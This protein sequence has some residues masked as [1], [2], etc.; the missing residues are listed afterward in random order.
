LFVSVKRRR[1]AALL[2]VLG[3]SGALLGLENLAARK[4]LFDSFGQLEREEGERSLQQVLKALEADLNQLAISNHDYGAWDDA[5][6]FANS[7]DP[8]FLESNFAT[9]TI[10]NLNVDVVWIIDTH[11]RDIVSFQRVPEI[12]SGLPPKA[13]DEVLG[14]LRSQLPGLWKHADTPPLSRLLQT[15]NGLLAFAAHPILP[16]GGRGEPRALL[17]FARFVDDA[18]LKRAHDT[19]QLPVALYTSSQARAVLPAQ[20]QALWGGAPSDAGRV[21]LTPDEKLLNG[22]A[23]I[24]DVNGAPA[25]IVG[26]HIGRK[27]F[28]FGHQTLRYLM[29]LFATVVALFATLL[30]ALL[31]YLEKILHAHQAAE[32][33]YKAVITEAQETMLLVDGDSRCILEANP[34]ATATLGFENA[35][36]VGMAIDD[37]FYAS[38][39]DVLRPVQPE[40]HASARADRILIVRRK[41][42]E[43][44]DVEVTASPLMIDGRESISF[45]LR[46]VSA[47][48]KAERQLVHNQD[49]LSHLAHHDALTGLLNR[50]GL[51]RRLPGL[52]QAAELGSWQVAFLYLDIDHFK[53]IN[54][55]RGHTVGDR[56]LQMA[57]ERLRTCLS[58]DDLIVRMGGDEF[59]VVAS[60]LRDAAGAATIATRIRE[61]LAEPFEVD[62]QE[63][64]VTSSVGV[65][66]YPDD[67]ADYE[68]L[69]KNA[70][71]ALYEAKDTGRDTFTLFSR[72]L[73]SR[74]SERL[75]IEH[76]LRDAIRGGQFFLEYQPLIDLQTNRIASLEALVRW[77]HP[78]RGLVPPMQFIDIA[79]KAGLIADIGEFVMR[80]AC[81]QIGEWDRAGAS[82]VPVAVNVSSRQFERQA[83]VSLVTSATEAANISPKMLHVELTESAF[84][85]G[86]ER[87][88]QHLSDLRALGVEVSVDDFGTGYS[89]LAYLKHLPID[90]L[91][92]DRAFV[93]DMTAEN[94]AAI[95]TAIIHMAASLNLTTV[96][97][98]VETLEQSRRLREL[99][100]TYAQGF[101]FSPPLAA[102]VCGRLLRETGG[103]DTMRMR[104]LRP[105]VAAAGG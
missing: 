37:L 53:K 18:M 46:D 20:A 23:L 25:A 105:A 92:I 76:E 22:Y 94:G 58:Q 102:D 48:K 59:V 19:S 29:V 84:M 91:K 93:R 15:S 70:D 28:A 47:R 39:G 99:G 67:G 45:V 87:H 2:I 31:L 38:D 26:T 73:T 16:T 89:S 103:S 85:D 41:N 83:I 65:S 21:L 77:R 69:L 80:E 95:V 8:R 74:V 17:V 33:R 34:A 1:L 5:F 96:A 72:N 52:I 12:E 66:V 88:V 9:E 82:V 61:K 104:T 60:Q 24:R 40:L 79:E 68:V 75:A 101:F 71:I 3:L 56:L 97:E 43:F 36:L 86:H 11:D 55:L 44:I 7:R 62:A 4:V 13:T 49:R 78:R 27:L 42:K 98:G 10:A 90:C 35:E 81:R 6:E 54:D 100:A 64:K 50:L 57:A 51:E 14:L 32:R 30:G 63:F